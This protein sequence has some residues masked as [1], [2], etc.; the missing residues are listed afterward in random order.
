MED[1]YQEELPL[2][3]S[4]NFWAGINVLLGCGKGAQMKMTQAGPVANG[5]FPTED[6]T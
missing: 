2:C 5:K 1:R 4:F 3:L 6:A